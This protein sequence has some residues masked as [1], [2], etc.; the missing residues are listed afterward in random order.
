MVYYSFVYYAC[1]IKKI[2]RILVS[3]SL[4]KLSKS[5]PSFLF[6]FSFK[7][8][9][10]ILSFIWHKEK[11]FLVS[12]F[13][14]PPSPLLLQPF[15]LSISLLCTYLILRIWYS[16]KYACVI[17]FVCVCMYVFVCVYICVFVCVCWLL[18]NQTMYECVQIQM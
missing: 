10:S 6:E 14:P 4:N 8:S 17:V 5:I 18:P 11:K 3:K 15:I 1:C 13:E 2:N 12:H 16:T 9:L 7:I